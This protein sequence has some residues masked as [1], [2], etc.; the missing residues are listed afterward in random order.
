LS[1]EVNSRLVLP[2][3]VLKISG[4]PWRWRASERA[5]VQKRALRV[6]DSL[7]EST[8]R[9]AQSMTATRYRKPL[10]TGM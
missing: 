2:W 7:Q 10:W 8:R 9:V 4:R 1:T 5:S 3:S 6:F